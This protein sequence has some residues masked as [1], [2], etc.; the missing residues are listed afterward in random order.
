[1][2]FRDRGTC[3]L[4]Q[5]KLLV[6]LLREVRVCNQ[7][8]WHFARDQLG[9]KLRSVCRGRG[10]ILDNQPHFLQPWGK[11]AVGWIGI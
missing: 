5:A 2:R 4:D 7:H 1:M 10:A 9:Q 11:S 6:L 3:T 8:R